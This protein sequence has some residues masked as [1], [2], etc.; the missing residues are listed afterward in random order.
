MNRPNCGNLLAFIAVIS[1]ALTPLARPA[2]AQDRRDL[3]LLATL[4]VDA[5]IDLHYARQYH[6]AAARLRAAGA[7]L[8]ALQDEPEARE[9][10][11]G[12]HYN[13]ACAMALSGEV[14]PALAELELAV[15]GG[16]EDLDHLQQDHDL[17]S[18][19]QQPR[20]QQLLRVLATLRDLEK[21]VAVA[22]EDLRTQAELGQVGPPA[23]FKAQTLDGA[24]FK[25]SELRGKIVVLDLWGTWCPPCRKALPEVAA[26]AERL[27]QTH[28]EE[29]TVLGVA[30]E[31]D[32]T[33]EEIRNK[34][35]GL[36]KKAAAKYP[37]V[38]VT[39]DQLQKLGNIQGFPSTAILDAQGRVRWLQ[40]GEVP[41]EAVI[42]I[43]DKLLAERHGAGAPPINLPPPKRAKHR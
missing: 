12:I 6:M 8:V 22:R 15:A 16:F 32:D 11:T 24:A 35:S 36:L 28:G 20:M 40:A 3:V 19:R 42:K 5:A 30:F 34:A 21:S 4:A 27:A 18:L 41:Q 43:V 13:L 37:C 39:A 23:Q 2:Q 25:L 38:V 10:L 29:V 7:A 9:M 26:L 1:L 33:S 31:H 14:E 17:D